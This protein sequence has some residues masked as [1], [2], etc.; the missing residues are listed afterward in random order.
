MSYQDQPHLPDTHKQDMVLHHHNRS[1]SK[2]KRLFAE[3]RTPRD[4]YLGI[5]ILIQSSQL[6]KMPNNY[7]RSISHYTSLGASGQESYLP[8][9]P[10]FLTGVTMP[11]V[12]QFT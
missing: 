2:Y 10:W 5:A 1:T 12:A 4:N 3:V 9:C 6:R 11:S 7:I 8:H